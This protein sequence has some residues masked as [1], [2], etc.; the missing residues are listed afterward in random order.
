MIAF[1]GVRK[2]WLVLSKNS[3]FARLAYSARLIAA[4]NSASDSTRSVTSRMMTVAIR[5][6]RRWVCEMVVSSDP[7]LTT[8][9]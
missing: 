4:R 3:V 7:A 9:L 1:K 2:S 8:G 6:R 5:S